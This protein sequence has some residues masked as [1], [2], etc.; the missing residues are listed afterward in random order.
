MA[1]FT[2][3]PNAGRQLV[4]LVSVAEGVCFIFTLPLI[5]YFIE[6]YGW[7]SSFLLLCGIE[8]HC[9]PFG[10]IY[11]M[12]ADTTHS[13]R[14]TSNHPTRAGIQTALFSVSEKNTFTANKNYANHPQSERKEDQYELSSTAATNKA[15]EDTECND[16]NNCDNDSTNDKLKHLNLPQLK[17]THITN[18][19]DSQIEEEQPESKEKHGINLKT[20]K[21]LLTNKMYTL[22]LISTITF[23]STSMVML[24]IL[25]DFCIQRGLSLSQGAWN[26]AISSTGD[27]IAR[28]LGSWFLHSKLLPSIV[29]FFSATIVCGIAMS[30]YITVHTPTYITLTSFF[31][32][33]FA[34]LAYSQYNVIFLDLLELEDYP[35]GI[36]LN[37]SITGIVL[38]LCGYIISKY[39]FIISK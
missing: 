29:I 34:G 39:S 26:S 10:L 28:L 38:L 33:L 18:N 2:H 23:L 36:G 6:S 14:K 15:F 1:L 11:S 21:R 35:L 25:P 30:V 31:F 16:I 22:S 13:N 32:M 37:E 4:S 17:N 20:W 27:I 7:R 9:V 24:T 5:S 12:K 3:F 19:V 8:M